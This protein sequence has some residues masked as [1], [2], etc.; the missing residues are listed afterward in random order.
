MYR[1]QGEESCSFSNGVAIFEWQGVQSWRRGIS[2]GFMKV[3]EQ[4]FEEVLFLGV[5]NSGHHG[6]L[7]HIPSLAIAQQWHRYQIFR[8][9]V[10]RI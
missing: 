1:H 5:G 10:Y 6:I 4:V 7:N 2:C 9:E 3:Y 8:L